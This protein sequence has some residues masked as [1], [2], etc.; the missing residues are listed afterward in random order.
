MRLIMEIPEC[1]YTSIKDVVDKGEFE[2]QE[3]VSL[4]LELIANGIPL[5][6]IKTDILSYK[7]D[8][9]IHAETNEMIDIVLEIIDEHCG[10]EDE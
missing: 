7:D 3:R 6:D 10:G 8:K 4:P 2:G 9:I 5:D 1:F